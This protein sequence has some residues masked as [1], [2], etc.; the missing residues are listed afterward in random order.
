[1]SILKLLSIYFYVYAKAK[2][3]AGFGIWQECQYQG[4][5]DVLTASLTGPISR[6]GEIHY[7]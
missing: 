4:Y 5:I 1:M 2:E 6:S 7:K 3:L